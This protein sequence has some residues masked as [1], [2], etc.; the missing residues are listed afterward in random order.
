MIDEFNTI[1]DISEGFYKDRGSKFYSFAFPVETENEINEILAE[2]R[3]KYYDA[4]HHC[5]AWRLGADK[6]RFRSND[7]G[8]PSN[9][10]GPP[11]LGQIKSFDLTNVLVVNIRYFGGTL[12]GVGG[13]IT[14]NK[15]AAKES[16]SAAEIITKTVNQEIYFSFEY[17]AMNEV[18]KVAKE[19][20]LKPLNQT[21]LDNCKMSLSIRLG[22]LERIKER[23]LKIESLQLL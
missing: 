18:M 8:E 3:K 22:N 7:D 14:A 15:T 21:Y 17:P 13:L 12:L 6:D 5:Y 16:L 19:E 11:I 10:A 23:L 20:D 1:K 4:R 2:L 9:S